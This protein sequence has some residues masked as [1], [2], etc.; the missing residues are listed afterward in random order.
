MCGRA[1]MR[2]W[3]V[4][5]LALLLGG[6]AVRSQ[7]AASGVEF[8]RDVRPIL[9]DHCFSCHSA[10]KKKGQLRLDARS[11]AM[12]GGL[13]GK[14]IVPGKAAASPLYAL[15]N[16]PDDDA[17]MPQKAPPLPAAKIDVIRRWIDQGAPWPDAAAGED[18]PVVP[19]SYLK[20]V[21]AVPPGA[22]HPVDAFLDAALK[23]RGL[24]PRPEAARATLLRRVTLDLIGLPPTPAE[25]A[26]FEADP[27]PGAYERVVDRLLADPRHGE[28]WGRHFMDVWRYSDWA[29]YQAEVRES[30]PNIWRWRDWIVESLNADKPYDRMIV[31]ML[32]GD[33]I[34]PEDPATLRA[35]G[36]LVRNWSKFSRE[37]WLQATVEHTAKAFLATTMN[38]ARCHDHF[39][40]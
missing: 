17:R 28:R 36:F 16:S 19:W 26:A 30:Q 39:F 7:D 8:V 24:A 12:K 5:G 20:P 13:G 10:A 21:A 14:A 22:G 25:I 6:G 9:R 35:T 1:T 2:R 29:G 38:C 23:A 31:E 40:D 3:T 27:S 18:A 15:L 4:A 37:V 33:E 34:A 32:A 11:A